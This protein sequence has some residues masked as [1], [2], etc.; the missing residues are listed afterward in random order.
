MIGTITLLLA[1]LAV[2]SVARA[3]D[4]DGLRSHL[5]HLNT[6]ELFELFESPDR[7]LDPENEDVNDRILDHIEND[8]IGMGWLTLLP[9]EKAKPGENSEPPMFGLVAKA[10]GSTLVS[11]TRPGA[12]VD[13]DDRV[14]LQRTVVSNLVESHR[15]AVS[16]YEDHALDD[17]ALK[18]VGFGARFTARPGLN[19]FGWGLRLQL[20]GSF[21]PS[22]GG[23]AYLAIT[24]SSTRAEH[25]SASAL[26]GP[27]PSP[28]R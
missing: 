24:G 19:I 11:L 14:F 16:V 13:P 8:R 15:F 28:A 3:G 10:G 26:A 22:H 12:A 21:H 27:S 4:G 5:L 20:F 2:A 9:G 25:E 23:T 1:S 6:R 17:D 18:F 7:S